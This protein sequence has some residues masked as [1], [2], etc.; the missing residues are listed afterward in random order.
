MLEPVEGQE[1]DRRWWVRLEPKLGKYIPLWWG[2]GGGDKGMLWRG[3]GWK[4][5]RITGGY[6]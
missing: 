2:K 1:R 6:K 5:G 4:N 3:Q